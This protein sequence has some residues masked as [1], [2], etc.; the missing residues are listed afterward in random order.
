MVVRVLDKVLPQSSA[1]WEVKL[2]VF[3]FGMIVRNALMI[4]EVKPCLK[5]KIA[6]EANVLI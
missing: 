4:Q 1:A 2:A 5:T 6:S 3:T